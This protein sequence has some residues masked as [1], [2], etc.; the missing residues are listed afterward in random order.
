MKLMPISIYLVDDEVQARERLI[1]LLNEFLQDE[2]KIIGQASQAK[3]AIIEILKLEPQIVLMDVE[4]PGMTGIELANELTNKGYQGKIIFISAHMHYSI[5][6]IRAEAFD[7]I[8]KPVDIDELKQAIERY[9]AK[10]RHE[11]NPAVI[12]NFDLSDREV[13][14]IHY[15]ASGLSS[16]EIASK[17]FLS[18]HT[19]DTHRRNI[20]TKTGAKNTIDLLNLLKA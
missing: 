18:R 2:I 10:A 1:Y 4:M 8:L 11:F 12:K 9:I 16:E 17:V 13:E 19:I 7:Y 6:A 14:L 15:L 5:K 3:R 20:L